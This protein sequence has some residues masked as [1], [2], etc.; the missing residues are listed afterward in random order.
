MFT[1]LGLQPPFP[2]PL[3][4]EDVPGFGTGNARLLIDPAGVPVEKVQRLRRTYDPSR[5]VELAAIALAGLAL[6]HAG[7]H[8]IRDVAVRG[9]AADYLIDDALHLLEIAGRSRRVDVIAAWEQRW[10]R[11]TNRLSHGFYVCVM[12]FETPSGRLAFAPEN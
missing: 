8:E 4:I 12:E 6:H 9:S 7:G 3:A 1:D 10:L 11:L 2:F 5:Q